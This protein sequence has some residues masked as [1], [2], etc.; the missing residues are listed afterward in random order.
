MWITYVEG[1]EPNPTDSGYLFA[2]KA[3]QILG[4]DQ[5][6]ILRPAEVIK[7]LPANPDQPVLLVDDFVGSG[8]QMIATWQRPYSDRL[9]RRRTTDKSR[10]FAT[11]VQRSGDIVYVPIIAAARGVRAITEACP[12]LLVRPAHVV[13]EK[14]SLT[15]PESILWPDELKPDAASFLRSVSERAGIIDACPDQWMGFDDLALALAFYHSVPDATLPLYYWEN[16]AWAP[17]V[18]RG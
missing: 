10:A 1:E 15:H 12:G 13:D 11:M 7:Q 9:A 6:Q 18:R 17:L 3:R 2:R 5:G 8:S 14:Y 16:E 4:I